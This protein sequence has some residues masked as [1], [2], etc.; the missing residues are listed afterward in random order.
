MPTESTEQHATTIRFLGTATVVPEAGHDTASFLINDRYLVDTGWYAAIKMKAYG[1]S[2]M[3]LEYVFI[4]HCHHDHYIGLPQ[5]LFYLRMRQRERPD[6]PPLKIVGP[7]ADI[8]HVVELARQLLQPDRFPEAVPMPIVL[9]IKPGGSYEE[10]AFRVDTCTTQ[11]PVQ[12]LCYRF[13][14]KSTG[15]V[16]SFTGD[17]AYH[18]PIIEHVQGSDLLIHEASYG[19]REMGSDPAWGHSG[20]PDAARIAVAAGVKELALIHCTEEQSHA[21]LKAAQ[22]IFPK[23]FFPEDG[24]IVTLGHASEPAV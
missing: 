8:E 1:I 17:T 15:V 24:Q 7:A 9:P 23:T 3:D 10:D 18:P 22:Q 13:Q 21:S 4:T 5:I 16:F 14:D 20:A 19:P 6:R 11:H 2:P 12:G